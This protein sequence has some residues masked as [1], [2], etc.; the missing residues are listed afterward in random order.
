MKC[1]F[2]ETIYQTDEYVDECLDYISQD[3]NG[4]FWIHANNGDKYSQGLIYNVR[5]CPYC[6]KELK[7]DE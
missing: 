2:C 5:Y 4:K 6:G 7:P 1:S 3:D